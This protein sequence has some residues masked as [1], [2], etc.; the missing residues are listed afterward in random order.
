LNPLAAYQRQSAQCSTRVDVIL[1]IFDRLVG[2]LEKALNALRQRKAAAPTA[3]LAK[4]RL[5]ALTL[6]KGVNPAG[7][8]VAANYQRLYDYLLYS[9]DAASVDNVEGAL[10]VARTLREGFLQIRPEAARMEHS[11]E[12]QPL[13][14]GR[15]LC[16]SA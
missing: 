13:A 5:A 14:D 2:H 12:I 6:A 11:G 9:L 10:R 3:H 4:A 16:T 1:A 7:G 15:T 8:E